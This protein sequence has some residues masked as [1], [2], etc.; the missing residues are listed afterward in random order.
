MPAAIHLPKADDS[1]ARIRAVLE[2]RLNAEHPLP[3]F[4]HLPSATRD[5]ARRFWSQRA[6]TEYCALPVVSQIAL[7]LAAEGAPLDELASVAGILQDE[8]LHT[9]LSAQVADAFG[10]Y[11]E[12]IPDYLALDVAPLSAPST[13]PLVVWLAVGC[14]VGETVSRALIVARLERTT[15]PAL[16]ALT[17]RTLKDE[18][19]H[20]AFGW[21][22]AKRAVKQLS[23]RDK[24]TLIP[25]IESALEGAWLG[26]STRLLKGRGKGIERRQR[27]RVADA[28]LGSCTPEEEDAAVARCIDGFILPNFEKLGL[29]VKRGR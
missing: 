15:D 18:N 28:G 10:G 7:K 14:C 12:D 5:A 2:Q 11:V 27:Q 19:V 20:V 17:A 24:R 9:A 25:W 29:A 4:K 1:V 8:S 23:P 16:K 3:S 26:P 13:M 6:W 22:A 21:A